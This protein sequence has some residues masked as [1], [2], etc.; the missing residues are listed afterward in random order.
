MK[1][2]KTVKILAE[3]I[4]EAR[5][6]H[7]A[8]D[9]LLRACELSRCKATCCHDGV[10]ISDEEGEYVES[11]V[12]RH[13]SKMLE[14]GLSLP[15]N[16]LLRKNKGMKTAVRDALPTELADDFPAHFPKTRCVFL[17]KLGHCGLQSLAME[18]GEDEWLHKPLTCW[19]HPLVLIPAGKWEEQP[20]LTIVNSNDDPLKQGSYAGYASCTHC[21]RADESGKPAWQ[22]LE[23]ELKRLGEICGRDVYAELSAPA[24]DW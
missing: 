14:Y 20:V 2:P 1:F 5:V 21:G 22:V 10:H 11:L 7:V 9:T 19:M 15:E 6:D 12:S 4:R 24:C 13:S 23:K 17:N 18:N 16:F 3:Q 8:F